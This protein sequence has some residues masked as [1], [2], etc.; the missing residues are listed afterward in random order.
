MTGGGRRNPVDTRI[1]EAQ[2]P[3]IKWHSAVGPVSGD[4]EPMDR[5]ENSPCTLHPASPNAN[6]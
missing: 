3:Y 4:V 1:R 6:M 2:V 5:T